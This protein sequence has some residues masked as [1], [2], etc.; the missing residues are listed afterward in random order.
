M[1]GI[2]NFVRQNSDMSNKNNK[3]VYGVVFKYISVTLIPI[4]QIAT[5]FYFNR[6][7]VRKM[8]L[9]LPRRLPFYIHLSEQ[10]DLFV[11][12]PFVVSRLENG[13]FLQ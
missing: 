4:F 8:Q 6:T 3:I 10:C 13:I 9:V 12:S 11:F 5:P 2:C 7:L 1:S